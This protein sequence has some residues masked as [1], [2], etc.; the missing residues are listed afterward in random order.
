MTNPD[1]KANKARLRKFPFPYA[2]AATVASDIDDASYD[3]FDAVHALF[4]REDV[5]RPGTA[6]WNTLGLS[7]ASAWYDRSAQGVRG[8]GLELADTFFLIGDERTLGMYRF[9]ESA[10]AFHEDLS[11]GRSGRAAIEDWIRRGDVD[12]F[13]GFHHYTRDQVLP[14]LRGF[15]EW[16][17][18]EGVAKPSVWINHSV[19]KC[20]S[21]LC[22]DALRPNRAV[23]FGRQLARFILGPLT[24][25]ERRRLTWRQPWYHGARPGSPHYVSD[26][27]RANGLK[28]VWLEAG[29]DELAN[30]IALPESAHGGRP[31]ILEPVTMDDG[32]TYYRFR[33]CYGK[34]GAR[35]GVTVALRTSREAFDAS[36]IFT[37][38]NLDRLCQVQGVCVLYTHWTVPRSLPVQDE[39]IGN[40]DR[41]RGYR[42]RGKIWVTRLSR[43]LEWTRLWAFLEYT[44]DR[45]ADRLIIDIRGVNDPV[46]GRGP[47]TL[48]ECEGLAFDLAHHDGPV[49]IRVAGRDLPP[50]SVL[51]GPSVCWIAGP[52]GRGAA[53]ETRPG[54][55]GPTA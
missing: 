7:T 3:R 39:T 46:F 25:R 6:A 54:A 41:L 38:E 42:D 22:P 10:R 40:F 20:P 18:R 50:D 30:V 52:S 11:D 34:V 35:P 53:G 36:T 13:H 24:G 26:V 2:A 8:L 5:I 43:L 14:L 16:C 51:R 12:A 32:S 17:E 37:A 47:L 29:G 23:W 19:R 21:G 55:G 44:E 15:Y 1:M 27:L 33:R 4:C 45:S 9:D 49:V 28:Y 48:P 31:S